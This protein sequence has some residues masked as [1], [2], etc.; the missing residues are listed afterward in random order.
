M[1]KAVETQPGLGNP[2]PVAKR[3]EGEKEEKSRCC[4][5]RSGIFQTFPH[6]GAGLGQWKG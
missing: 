5:L 2:W 4:R 1:A 6:E 3:E